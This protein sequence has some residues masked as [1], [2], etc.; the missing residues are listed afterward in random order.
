M[1]TCF[2]YARQNVAAKMEIISGE[3]LKSFW[4]IKDLRGFIFI[5]GRRSFCLPSSIPSPAS[6]VIHNLLFIILFFIYVYI[7]FR[8]MLWKVQSGIAPPFF[9]VIIAEKDT[10]KTWRGICPK[11]Q[12][13]IEPNVEMY[14][15]DWTRHFK[16]TFLQRNV[17]Q[18]SSNLCNI[19]NI[20]LLIDYH[21]GLSLNAKQIWTSGSSQDW[22]KPTK[23]ATL[24]DIDPLV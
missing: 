18:K 23:C 2:S 7:C 5:S 14:P 13:T 1:F 21:I 6:Q 22:W 8:W 11:S 20:V 12:N 24:I 4:R 16:F 10:L 15:V 9:Y 17:Y 3:L 19:F